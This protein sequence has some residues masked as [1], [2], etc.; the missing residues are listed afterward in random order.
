M[1]GIVLSEEQIRSAPA[2]VRRWL[3]AVVEGTLQAGHNLAYDR[4]GFRYA[5]DELAICDPQEIL[6]IFSALRNDAAACQIF[7]RLGKDNYDRAAGRHTAIPITDEELIAGSAI[8]AERI[9]KSLADVNRCLRSVRN[10]PQATLFVRD[11][12]GRVV[13]HE[14]T[15]W[16]IH[17]LLQHLVAASQRAEAAAHPYRPVTCAPPYAVAT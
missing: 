7:F 1:V 9:D 16:N 3:A 10:D 4:G 8:S 13:V 11:G 14:R 15:Q 5:E 17:M 6:Q 2:E 12:A